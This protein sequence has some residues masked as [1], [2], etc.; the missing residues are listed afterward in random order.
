MEIIYKADDGTIFDNEDDCT[1]YE[2][3]GAFTEEE[4]RALH[5]WNTKEQPT[6]RPGACMY[7][8]AD[9]SGAIKYARAIFDCEG[10]MLPDEDD[11]CGHFKTG[12]LY[13]YVLGVGWKC[14]Q[15]EIEEL[16][17]KAKRFLGNPRA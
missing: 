10:Y 3:Y 8:V 7:I 15:D 4:K 2:E 1:F 11:A 13:H 9:T 16:Q 6:N 14:L 12:A 17:A 5:M